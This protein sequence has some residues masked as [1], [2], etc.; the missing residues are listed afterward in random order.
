MI[1][2]ENI[3]N[4]EKIFNSLHILNM[5]KTESNKDKKPRTDKRKNVWKVAEVLAVNPN[6]TDREIAKET[7]IWKSTVN[8]AKEE[9]GQSWLLAKIMKEYEAKQKIIS[10]D[11]KD[12]IDTDL[13]ADF[14][15]ICWSRLEATNK[16]EEFMRISLWQNKRRRSN[17]WNNTR[18]WILHKFWF[19]C[20]ACGAKPNVDNDVILQID[21]IV[22]YSL[23][24]LDTDNNYQV[25][26]NSC[27]ASKWDNFI[28]YHK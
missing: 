17:V 11:I 25:L 24:W 1:V 23:G 16:I 8:R 6:K 5:V 14:V 27:N 12:S 28:Y 7:G 9:L 3:S 15:T 10:D 18:Y 13:L 19:K 4:I 26:C 20:C 2:N 21:H 22:P